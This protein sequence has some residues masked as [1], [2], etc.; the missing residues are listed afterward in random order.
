MADDHDRQFGPTPR[1]LDLSTLSRRRLLTGLAGAGLVTLVG[2]RPL[3]GGAKAGVT[4]AEIPDETGGPY[5]ADGTNGPNVLTQRGVVRH[6]IRSSFGSLS[7]TADGVGMVVDLL[8]QESST[9]KALPGAAVYLWHCDRLGRYSLYS[10]GATNQNYLRG[11]QVAG[12][13]GWV[14][15]KSIFPGAYSGRWP[16]IH[17]EVYSSQAAAQAAGTPV[18]TS[19]LALPESVCRT[20]YA[21]AGYESGVTNLARTTL[22]NDNVFRDGVT[23]QLAAVNG[24]VKNGFHAALTVPV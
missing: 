6:D 7:G 14:S 24:D 4:S 20:A 23:Q 18:K 3:P 12:A 17:F 21:T 19:Q 16:H 15:F 22:A 1:A 13:D 8:L 9:G 10:P 11:V 2:C 5:P